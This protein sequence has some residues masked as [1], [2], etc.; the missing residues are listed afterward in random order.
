MKKFTKRAYLFLLRRVGL[1]NTFYGVT[2]S[3]PAVDSSELG[4]QNTRV[5]ITEKDH[6]DGNVSSEEI[7]IISKLVAKR[8]PKTIFEIGTFDGR[9]TINMA[10]SAPVDAKIYT[11]DL[12]PEHLNETAFGVHK[13]DLPYIQKAV[14]GARHKNKPESSKITQLYGDSG[15][16]DF[17]PFAGTVDFIFVDGSHAADYVVND[18][19]KAFLMS[20]RGTTSSILWHDYG[21]WKDVTDVMNRY[22]KKD[23]RFKGLKHIKNTSLVFLEL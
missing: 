16:F 10:R 14:V 19:E 2:L 6:T 13:N 11:L 4:L 17:G 1:Y 5:E 15:S 21:V 8:K 9:T 12:L 22:Y 3:V 20:K 18:T 7:N 23:K